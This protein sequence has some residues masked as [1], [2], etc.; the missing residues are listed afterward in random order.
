MSVNVRAAA[1]T[2]REVVRRRRVRDVVRKCMVA[3]IL[4]LDLD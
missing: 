1:R 4:W 3:L 2:W